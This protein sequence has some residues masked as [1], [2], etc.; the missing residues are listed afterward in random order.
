LAKLIGAKIGFANNGFAILEVTGAEIGFAIFKHLPFHSNRISSFL[1][2][3][4]D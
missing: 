4:G 1:N 2:K 3:S